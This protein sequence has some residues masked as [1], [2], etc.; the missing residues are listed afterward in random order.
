ME[1]VDITSGNR[2]FVM[3]VKRWEFWI[4]VGGTFTDCLARAPD[5]STRRLKLLSSGVTKGRVG[6]GST[7]DAIV[8]PARRNDPARFLGRLAARARRRRRHHARCRRGRRLR[9]RRRPLAS[10]RSRARPRPGTNYELR[11]QL[12]AP[13]VAIRYLLGLPLDRA[14]A[15]GRRAAGHDARHER[16]HHAPRRA[17][18]ARHDA[19]LRRRAG[20]RLPG[21]AAAVRSDDPQAAA[22]HV[23]GRRNRRARDARRAKCSSRRTKPTVRQQLAI[24]A[25]RRHRVAG[26]LPA[27]RR[28]PPRARTTGRPHRPRGRLPRDQRVARSRAAAEDRRPGRHDGRRRVFEPGA[29]RLCRAARGVAAGQPDAAADVRRRAGGGRASFAARTAFSPGRPAAWSASRA[30]PQAAGFDAA[31]GFDMGGTSTDVARFDV[32]RRPLRARVRNGKGRR[33]ASSRR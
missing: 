24:A 6:A 10:S 27:A 30:S 21:P 29:A 9:P 4:D 8:D 16:A 7:R 25:R 22:A 32:I 13:V 3:A 5:G 31:I 19:R 11:S 20:D 15:A 26:H 17:D 14:G 18:G 2:R 12:E 28:S 33:A 1:L 23:G